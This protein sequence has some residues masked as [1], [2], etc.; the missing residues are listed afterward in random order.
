[1]NASVGGLSYRSLVTTF[2]AQLYNQFVTVGIQL[3]TIPLLL[4]SWG[5]ERYGVWLLLSAVPTYLT[6][7]DFGFTMAAKNVMTIKVVRG[8]KSGALV[9]Y[10][11]IFMLL[12]LSVA[13][14]LVVLS[15]GLSSITL[16]NIFVLGPIHERAAKSILL[17]LAVNVLLTQYLL[18]LASGLRCVGRPTEEVVWGASARL[19]E[20][21]ATV[22]IAI[23]GGDLV[24]AAFAIVVNRF[25][26]LV[27]VWFR[28]RKLER[29]LALG[30]SHSSFGEARDLLHPSL[31]FMLVSIGQA[32]TIQGPILIL[33]AIGTP[34]QVVV[35]STARTLARL[36]TSVVNMMNF[37]STPEYSRLYGIGDFEQFG[38]L[39]RAHLWLTIALSV[40]YFAI[41][42]LTGETV[43][44]AWS[45]GSIMID[46]TF[47][48]V[49]LIAVAGEM[50]WSA[51]LIPLVSVNRHV[52]V[53]RAFAVLSVLALTLSYIAIW[54]SGSLA[55]MTV[56]LAALHSIM[57][58]LAGLHAR[59]F[60]T[61]KRH[62]QAE[63]SA[64]Q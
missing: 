49:L 47:L 7:A 12:N 31:S 28:L 14:V 35:F 6:F 25:F 10:Q 30:T 45:G 55:S 24:A 3:A 2:G 46:E 61:S 59:T 34:V 29:W 44:S 40:G 1:M 26:F 11:S 16:G 62:T 32:L 8:D 53:S 19:V 4:H 21:V 20:G 15:I 17:L 37:A 13:S 52:A 63:R 39:A 56:P 9:T 58:Y 54:Y 42:R 5:A 38:R 50:I 64:F 51:E 48:T 22:L 41:L 33:G 43:I 57:I 23:L 60:V 36:G 18:L 27:A